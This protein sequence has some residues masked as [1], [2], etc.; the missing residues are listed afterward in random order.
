MSPGSIITLRTFIL[1]IGWP[2]LIVGSVVLSSLG[3]RFAKA[4]KGTIFAKLVFPTVLG[5]LVTMYIL[6]ITATFYMFDVPY[7]GTLIV[8]PVFIIWFITFTVLVWITYRWSKEALAV[9]IFYGK[10]EEEVKART[11]ELQETNEHLR[12]ADEAKSQFV[13]IAAHQFRTPLSAI[14]WT[15]YLLLNGDLGAISKE[16]RLVLEDGAESVERLVVLIGDLLN[17]ARIES[18]KLTYT[19]ETIMLESLFDSLIKDAN[20]RLHEKEIVLH[21]ALPDSPLP[22][23]RG[24]RTKLLLAFQNVLENAMIYTPKNG[25]IT[26]TLRKED[27]RHYQVVISDTGM[28]IPQHQQVL[29]FQKFFRADNVIREQISG[30]GLG[31]YMTK[32]V[33][34]AHGGTITVVSEEQKGSTFTI[35]IPFLAE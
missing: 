10:L 27:E 7:K 11:Q 35:T 5:W 20:A 4:T 25:V 9:R 33:V 19:F 6:G 3:W 2:V 17:V 18:G 14:K 26:A 1:A 16:Q 28:G 23:A 32:R 34:E 21:V 29:L 31:L 24:D 13:S 15:I 12:E 22:E 8:F 30:T